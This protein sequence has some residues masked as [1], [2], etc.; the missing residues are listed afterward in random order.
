MTDQKKLINLFGITNWIVDKQANGLS[1]AESMLQA[2]FRANCF[3]WILGH[4]LVSRDQ[5]LVLL[6]AEPTL[7]SAETTLY[8]TDSEALTDPDKAVPLEGLLNKLNE[9]LTRL[10]A[11]LQN[12]SD[13]TLNAIYNEEQGTTVGERIASLHWHETY[14]LGQLE[15]LRQL[16]GTND[17]VI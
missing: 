1:H 9:S 6:K 13:E 4:V 5:A 3:N 2:P 11:S 8:E 12:A 7:N 17:K 10:S 15:I 16:A 14:H